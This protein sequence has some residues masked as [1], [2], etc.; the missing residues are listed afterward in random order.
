MNR[1]IFL[2]GKK[3]DISGSGGNAFA[4]LGTVQSWLRQCGVSRDLIDEFLNEAKS[5]DYDHL[6]KTATEATGVEFVN[7]KEA[8]EWLN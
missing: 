6:L 1:L 2:D 3:Y 5:G 8:S 4:I 7:G